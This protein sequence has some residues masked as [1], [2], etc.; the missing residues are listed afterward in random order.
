MTVKAANI[1]Q[2]MRLP[3]TMT[4]MVS[5][6]P[7]LRTMPSA[8][9]AQLI[10]AIFAPAQIHICCGPV[11]SR[12]ASGMGST[13]WTSAQLL[14]GRRMKNPSISNACSYSVARHHLLPQRGA[15][16]A[17]DGSFGCKQADN[18]GDLSSESWARC[19]TGK[20]DGKGMGLSIRQSIIEALG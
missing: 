7:S 13:L 1:A 3:T 2:P 10:G 5:H 11:E 6:S 20:P 4:A 16:E 18:L 17:G 15:D 9:S 8:P 14:F 19:W 12:S